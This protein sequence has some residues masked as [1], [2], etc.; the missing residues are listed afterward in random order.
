MRV[1]YIFAAIL[2]VNAVLAA[3]WGIYGL[4]AHARETKQKIWICILGLASAIWSTGFGLLC[5]VTD[6]TIAYYL[7]CVGMIGVFVFLVETLVLISRVAIL[8]GIWRKIEIVVAALS[9]PMYVATVLPGQAIFQMSDRGMSYSLKPSLLN[10][11]YSVYTI[12]VALL[13]FVAILEIPRKRSGKRY[14]VLYMHF[15]A[16]EFLVFVG[17]LLDTIFPMFGLQA[18]PGSSIAQFYGYCTLM[19][20]FSGI[21][22][23]TTTITNMSKFVYSSLSTPVCVCNS[24]KRMTLVNDAAKQFFRLERD[25]LEKDNISL[26]EFFNT[27]KR[28]ILEFEGEK[29]VE[30]VECKVN[31]ANCIVRMDKIRD[32][33]HDIIGY[34]VMVEDVSAQYEMMQ[35]LEKA[36]HAK[37]V[38]L[39]NMSHEIRTPMN[40]VIGFAEL[41]LR[42]DITESQKEYVDTIRESSYNL[43]G[44][45][46]E[47]LDI[48]KLDAGKEELANTE[49]ELK[50]VLQDVVTQLSPTAQRKGLSFKTII[51]PKLPT[52]VW[53]DESKIRAILG[54][55]IKNAITYTND[56][57]I[58]LQVIRLEDWDENAQIEIQVRD[59]GVGIKRED[60]DYICDAFA[61][62]NRNVHEGLEG[63]G[64]GLSIVKGFVDLMGGTLLIDS[65]FGKGTTV[66]IAV[67]Q[68]IVDNTPIQIE[69]LHTIAKQKSNITGA[70]LGGVPVLAVDDNEVNL[71]VISKCLECYQLSVDTA[72]SGKEAI[73]KCQNK[74]YQIIFMDQMMPE[75]DGVEAMKK[76]RELPD[77]EC[78]RQGS[79]SKIVAL[80]ANAVKGTREELIGLGF[81]EYLS[82][83]IEFNKLEEVLKTFI[84]EDIVAKQSEE[85]KITPSELPK[86]QEKPEEKPEE[87]A[88][89]LP[90]VNMAKGIKLCGGDEESYIEVLQIMVET[91][92]EKKV[93]MDGKWRSDLPT[94]QID[95]HGVKGMCYNIGA[96]AM[97]DKAKELEMAAKAKDVD[98][99]EANHKAFE[100]QFVEFIKMI[101]SYLKEKGIDVPEETT[102]K[103]QVDFKQGLLAIKNA[104]DNF[105]FPGASKVLE[106]LKQGA[107]SEG[108]TEALHEVEALVDTIDV[109]GLASFVEQYK[110]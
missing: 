77:R 19:L 38:F 103:P 71:K 4:F 56:G 105:D 60:I 2:L 26:T 30:G 21:E 50:S 65:E 92:R 34:I 24:E 44:T 28:D 39:A 20:A 73:E 78:Y 83:P 14:K 85:K 37:S 45:I 109:D 80:T 64:L 96:D 46:N 101:A 100:E 33:F 86:P 8:E 69:K 79:M 57:Y 72:I 99:I 82:K 31:G 42:E 7:R 15:L 16:T 107:L 36:N 102:D 67:P 51:D 68:K 1:N 74:E 106:E 66:K 32:S 23:T 95:I 108:E 18:I 84:S 48:A 43:L 5:L 76:I 70:S 47:I 17:M 87:E 3:D 59:T 55:I 54:H 58:A 35:N 98:F 61:Q 94:Y 9:I 6:E 49:Y 52:K 97:G 41:L 13:I 91:G 75:M 81:D 88:T 29:Q 11:L 12:V 40:S 62:A 90:G 93:A 110:A 63:T 22:K 53:G 104:M 25:N 89:A 10:N 27:D